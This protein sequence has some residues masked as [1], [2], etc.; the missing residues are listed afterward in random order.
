MLGTMKKCKVGKATKKKQRDIKCKD[1]K[2]HGIRDFQIFARRKGE[3]R[4]LR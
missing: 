3:N 4:D 2:K 1:E